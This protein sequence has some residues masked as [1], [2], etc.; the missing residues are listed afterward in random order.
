MSTH[1]EELLN[2]TRRL[3]GYAYS[4][5]E[6]LAVSSRYEDEKELKEVDVVIERAHRAIRATAGEPDPDPATT[7]KE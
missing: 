7:G 1:D 6:T 2:V 3:L 4:Y 5:R